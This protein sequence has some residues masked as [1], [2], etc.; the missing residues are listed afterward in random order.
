MSTS[1][2]L[3]QR[4][5]TYRAAIAKLANPTQKELG[6]RTL[7]QLEGQHR[8]L[9]KAGNA[10]GRRLARDARRTSEV[11]MD[12]MEFDLRMTRIYALLTRLDGL[13]KDVQMAGRPRIMYVRD[14]QGRPWIARGGP[15]ASID[16]SK[17]RA[18]DPEAQQRVTGPLTAN[19]ITGYNASHL[20][21]DVLGGSG[22]EDNLVP[23]RARVNNSWMGTLER[24]VRLKAPS[25]TEVYAEVRAVYHPK[26]LLAG[27]PEAQRAWMGEYASL[28][29]TIPDLLL[30]SVW[31]RE[32]GMDV[33]RENVTFDCEERA[34]VATASEVAK[35]TGHRRA[36]DLSDLT[37]VRKDQMR[38]HREGV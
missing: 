28:I 17:L 22:G 15:L 26:D 33:R 12:F 35:R 20:I 38:T 3:L 1:P 4:I 13:V 10:L 7:A 37:Q 11:P 8:D 30:Y 2:G 19:G 24:K 27:V 14:A 18:R 21:A 5:T 25:G 34:V 29:A 31:E 32:D 9:Q 16:D 36:T 23:M 6:Q